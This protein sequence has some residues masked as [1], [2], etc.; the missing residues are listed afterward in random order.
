MKRASMKDEVIY[1]GFKDNKCAR[2]LELIPIP[3]KRAEGNNLKRL[4]GSA[5]LFAGLPP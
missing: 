2:P 1:F 4:L 3:N 5:D